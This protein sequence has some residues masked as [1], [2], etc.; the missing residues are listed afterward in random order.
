MCLIHAYSE[1]LVY[2]SN[3]WLSIRAVGTEERDRLTCFPRAVYVGS[4]C[5]IFVTWIFSRTEQG[6]N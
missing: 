6:Y 2:L 1:A 3:P 4:F 5:V